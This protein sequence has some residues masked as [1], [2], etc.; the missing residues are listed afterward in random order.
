MLRR[1]EL[2]STRDPQQ[3]VTDVLGWAVP[4]RV[5][6]SVRAPRPRDPTALAAARLVE[7]KGGGI[8]SV[9]TR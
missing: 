5:V 6:A 7:E 3:H 9:R 8:L 1:L 4:G 2:P